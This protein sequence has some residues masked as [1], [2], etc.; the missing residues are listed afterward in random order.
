MRG[1][2]TLVVL[3]AMSGV[4]AAQP[5]PPASPP[6]AQ[7]ETGPWAVG[8]TE[9]Q[10]AQAAKGLE[11]GNAALLEGNHKV[12]LEHYMAAI[13]AW[14]H[15]AIRFN[16]VRALIY[17][18]RDVEA[19]DNL[20]LALKY[21][22]APLEPQIYAEAQNYKKLLRGKISEIEVTCSEP[23]TAVTLDGKSLM[24]CPGTASRRLAAGPHQL[25]AKKAAFLT[26]AREEMLL[27]GKK[28]QLTIDMIPLTEAAATRRRWASW[29]PWAVVGGGAV[30]A[31]LGGLLQWKA[32]RDF[33]RYD[34][35]IERR[36]AD[37]GCTPEMIDG[38]LEDVAVLEN[39]V[40]IGMM[41]IGGVALAGGLWMLWLN[42][43]TNYTPDEEQRS[44][45][46]GA[47]P[48]VVVAPV[49]APGGA[50]LELGVRF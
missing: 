25:V 5:A 8:V 43:P 48:S 1:V 31:G 12:A 15:P 36:C 9:E 30:V 11:A 38:T 17:L 22:D 2:A 16:I 26:Y 50:S 41:T 13:E 29:K 44:P 7:Q 10:K 19:Y 18:E 28:Q 24:T 45:E 35:R 39:R 14:D 6:P 46:A 3:A 40:A 27:P 47:Q 42:R 20:E 33:D 32:A 21:G 34:R 23:N 49:V 4:A 37:R